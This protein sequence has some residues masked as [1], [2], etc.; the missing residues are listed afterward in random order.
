[1]FVCS[2]LHHNEKN[3]WYMYANLVAE[4]NRKGYQYECVTKLAVV[5]EA[6][7][8]KI[9]ALQSSGGLYATSKDEEVLY[10]M[11]LNATQ[12]NGENL[13]LRFILLGHVIAAKVTKFFV[14]CTCFGTN[15]LRL[16]PVRKFR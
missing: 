1:M 2:P 8:A 12:E 7:V 16:I 5:K 14:P 9:Q 4:F 11:L 13:V 6:D 10:Q 15:N 3:G